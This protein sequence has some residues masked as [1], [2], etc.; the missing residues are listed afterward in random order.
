MTTQPTLG[1]HDKIKALH[2]L[3]C[4]ESGNSLPLNIFRTD[5]WSRWEAQGFTAEDLRLVIRYIKKNFHS[6]DKP[7]IMRSML[8]FR[9]LI[10]GE[11]RDTGIDYSYYEQH[12]C[13]AKAL[14][15]NERSQPTQKTQVLAA[16]NRSEPSPQDQPAERR[17]DQ[18]TEEV[19]KQGYAGIFKELE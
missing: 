6:P 2:I 18:I 9:K 1:S 15:R 11:Y 10:E 3:Y 14:A 5:V 12:L 16:V 13:D 8:H 17:V 19:L 7:H 4:T